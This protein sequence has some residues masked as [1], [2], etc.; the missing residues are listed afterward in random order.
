MRQFLM[1]L[2]AACMVEVCAAA[3]IEIARSGDELVVSVPVGLAEEGDGLTLV[4]DD[5]DQGEAEASWA[6]R[7]EIASSISASGGVFS[8]PVAELDIGFVYARV[9][10]TREVKL[11]D[12]ALAF[13]NFAYVDTGIPENEV[14]TLEAGF[15]LAGGKTCNWAPVMGA[16][17]DKFTVGCHNASTSELYLR[18]NGEDKQRYG[19]IDNSRC[20]D[21]VLRNRAWMVNGVTVATGYSSDA[22]YPS[23]QA[24][25]HL[26]TTAV[27][28]NSAD[29]D[30]YYFR[31]AGSSGQCLGNL[32][33]ARVGADGVPCF[34]DSVKRRVVP[35]RGT[36][37]AAASGVATN[38]VPALMCASDVQ[39]LVHG[40]VPTLDVKR[41]RV[42]HALTVAGL[43]RA[44]N[45]SGFVCAWYRGSPKKVYDSV[46]FAT[47]LVF[48]PAK[49]DAE[50]W[51]R[52]VAALGGC[53]CLEKEFYFS[54]LPVCY[55]TTDDGASPSE[56]KESHT[57][58][59][60]VQGND[61]WKSPYEGPATFNVRGNSTAKLEKKPYKVKLDEKK[62]MFGMPKSK[63]WVLLANYYDPSQLRNK[64]MYDLANEIGSLG[65]K[66]TWVQVVLNGKLK[67]VYQFCEHLR[68]S[69]N[70]VPVYDWEDAAESAA[71][72]I[73]QQQG[74]DKAESKALAAQMTQNLGWVTTGRVTWKNANY[75]VAAAWPEYV[76]D[77]SGG[78]LFEFSAEMDA[79]TQFTMPS[80]FLKMQTM[81]VSPEYL[82]TNDEMYNTAKGILQDY[83]DACTSASRRNAKGQHYAE[84]CDVESMTAYFLINEL[85]YDFDG[86][87]RSRFAYK[88]HGGK[89]VWGPVW[90]FDWSAR[91]LTTST[92]PIDEWACYALWRQ[93]PND[94]K[95]YSMFKEWASDWYFARKCREK[96]WAIRTQYTALFEPGGLIDQYAAKLA[97]A[98]EVDDRLWPRAR[99][100]AQDVAILKDYLSQRR[101]WLD[102]QFATT[103][104]FLESMRNPNMQT[105]VY[106]YAPDA[107][108][109]RLVDAAGRAVPPVPHEWL[110]V[111]A[112]GADPALG[113]ADAA[114][115]QVVVTNAPSVWG[116]AT[117][118]WMDYVA[119]TDP[120]PASTNAAFR[121][122]S[123]KVGADGS[124]QLD[125]QPDLGDQRVYTIE[126][127]ETLTP[128]AW[129]APTAK[130]RFF[131]VRADLPGNLK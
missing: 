89:L 69:S 66:S 5:H 110:R 114:T 43:D 7:R 108:T 56:R 44:T 102:A 125:W 18:Y 22:L 129:H 104:S 121:I 79:V 112:E 100:A 31:V 34:Y 61:E 85:C 37:T 68:V 123:I 30:W 52:C 84:L 92:V 105:H 113:Y 73:A 70:R 86:R 98:Y 19:R 2:V 90:D 13:R 128:A 27:V 115:L 122:S 46:P 50:H 15:S 57:G 26:G 64:L 20:N 21:F 51:F 71:E 32:V 39:L 49:A 35:V 42:G 67:G 77:L 48:T 120:D 126:G 8:T 11:V 97:A 117:P 109:P 41:P 75:E 78:Y 81:V 94:T 74:W 25:I 93:Y 103:V 82:K 62:K 106:S 63:H 76:N 58:T 24:A 47:G 116:K 88:D 60:F 10:L 80:G 12:G 99:T 4:W 45:D 124:V 118:L 29:T 65:M 53:V 55:L 130:D 111:A 96:Y 54:E 101:A 1:V 40:E 131:R 95:Y 16:S 33:P 6:H 17:H 72:A 36:G 23:G 59:L 3:G 38:T 83:W 119:G 14:V 9:L 87:Y 127:T 107:A 91:S 28:Q